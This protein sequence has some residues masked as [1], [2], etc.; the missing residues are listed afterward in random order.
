MRLSLQKDIHLPHIC[1]DRVNFNLTLNIYPNSTITSCCHMG[2]S[3][4]LTARVVLY[5]PSH[6]QDNTYHSLCYTSRG[7]LAGT[8][9]SSMSPLH[10]GSIRRPIAPWAN[11]LTTELHLAP[12]WG[13]SRSYGYFTMY[14][15]SRCAISIR[16]ILVSE[17]RYFSS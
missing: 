11:A 9:N 7:A 16:S 4:Q 8:S 6:I 12:F 3:F 1:I 13:W 17:S 10:E 5:A 14:A 2:Y 15:P